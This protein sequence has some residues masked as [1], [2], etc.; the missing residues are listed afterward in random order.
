MQSFRSRA[1]LLHTE[2]ENLL[3][4]LRKQIV[5]SLGMSSYVTK[6]QLMKDEPLRI[7]ST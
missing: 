7:L 5:D 4:A 2:R 3:S 6:G 1:L